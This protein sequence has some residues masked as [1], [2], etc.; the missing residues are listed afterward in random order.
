MLSTAGVCGAEHRALRPAVAAGRSEASAMKPFMR[1]LD[2]SPVEIPASGLPS[3]VLTYLVSEKKWRLEAAYGYRD[4]AQLITV[5]DQFEFD[6]ASIPRLFWWLIAPFELS[7]AAPLL[8]DFLYR[9]RGDPPAGLVEPP[10]SYNREEAD[11]LFRRMMAS[12]GVSRWRRAAAYRAVRWFGG[13]S[14]SL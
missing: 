4:G 8:H 6:L 11:R 9:Y 2:Q 14:W 3:P 10:R 7:I 5:P 13:A 12:E 1:E